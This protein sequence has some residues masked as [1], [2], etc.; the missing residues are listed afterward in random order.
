MGGLAQTGLAL[1][2]FGGVGRAC[3]HVRVRVRPSVADELPM[4]PLL[5]LPAAVLAAAEPALQPAITVTASR[6][7]ETVDRTLAAVDL[8]DRATIV[9][10]QARDVLELL[11]LRAGIDL[12]RT[13]GPGQQT[14]V[15]MRGSNANH[16]LVLIDGVRV[17]ASNTGAY[18][19]EHL[20]LAHIERIEIVRGPRAALYGSDAIGGV[21]QIF[22]RSGPGTSAL[23]SAGSYQDF[24]AAAAHGFGD[25]RSSLHLSASRRDRRGFSATNPGIAFGHDPD[26]D[27]LDSTRLAVAA[28]HAVGDNLDLSLRLLGSDADV[29]FDQGMSTQRDHSIALAL[30]HRGSERRTQDLRLGLARNDLRTLDFDSRFYSQRRQLDWLHA[31]AL[32]DA[33]SLG[34]GVNALRDRG[35]NA[36]LAGVQ[37]YGATRDSLG[38][39]LRFARQFAALKLDGSARYDHYDGFGGEFTGQ[40]AA[41][42]TLESGATLY[43]SFGEG[44]RAPNLNELYSP[45]FGGFF[46]GNPALG[47]ESARNLELGARSGLGAAGRLELNVYRSRIRD[48][49]AYEGGATFQAIN[50]ARAEI[51]GVEVS[52]FL[53]RTDWQARF[54][55]SWTDPQNADAGTPLLRR[56]RHKTAFEADWSPSAGL[57]LGAEAS[58][59]G[60]RFD[61]G[62]KA[63]GSYTLLALRGRWR[64]AGQWALEARLD[65][66]TDDDYELVSGYNTAG[67]G[68]Q[69]SL[70]YGD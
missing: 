15:F 67:R 55:H 64:L 31:L 66:L 34:F 68:A 7:L 9:D 62:Q 26:R 11:R 70:R 12:A 63:L 58:H 46:A 23:W 60:R 36:D 42:W 10:S 37:A 54:S 61:V 28:R 8:L 24:E 17:A 50:I 5:L 2:R 41:G 51:D 43:L 33:S 44:F 3:G 65:N 27:G 4:T 13:G 25:D 20:P 49:I 16:V 56:A 6:Q 69:L 21:I 29:A 22:T 40:L 53:E 35:F 14:S 45:G 19:F 32:D 38:G 1:T 18:T 52:W 39:Y 59:D 30:H 57:S 48:L 47:P